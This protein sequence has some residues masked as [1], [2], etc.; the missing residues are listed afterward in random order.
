[1]EKR[2]AHLQTHQDTTVHLNCL[3]GDNIKLYVVIKP[4]TTVKL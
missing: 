1:M 2:T 3:S 4:D